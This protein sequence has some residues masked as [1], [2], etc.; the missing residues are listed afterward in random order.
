MPHSSRIETIA[1]L[2]RSVETTAPAG[3]ALV[4]IDGVGASGKTTLADELGVAVRTRPVAVLHADD[5]FN[6]PEIRHA[7]GRHSPE[8]FWLD[9]YDYSRMISEALGPLR[10][11]VPGAAQQV[12]PNLLEWIA[13]SALNRDAH[14]A[15]VLVEGAFLHRHEL[16][17]YWDFSI[18]V[19]VPMVE[20]RRRMEL[21]AG[22]V[23]DDGLLARYFGAQQIYFRA[24]R[25]WLRATVV[26]D[27]SELDQARRIEPADSAAAHDLVH[28]GD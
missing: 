2:A 21:R 16:R 23:L 4:A 7:R 8:G 28:R 18:F 20:A 10:S 26:L 3:P 5:F 6:P 13:P 9:T 1:A 19:D 11:R 24:A 15:L 14:D 27:N 17:S 12:A 25:P 22:V